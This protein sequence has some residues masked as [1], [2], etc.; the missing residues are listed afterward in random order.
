MMAAPSLTFQVQRALNKAL[1]LTVI[2]LRGRPAAE[3]GR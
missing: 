3:L 1:Q 2:P